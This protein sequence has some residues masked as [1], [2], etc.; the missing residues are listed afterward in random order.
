MTAITNSHVEKMIF[1]LRG[2][3][4]MLD[5]DLAEL[6]GVTTKRL[7]EQVR[8]NFSRF[9]EDF[10]FECDSEDLKALRSQIATANA[11]S[12]WNHKRRNSPMVFTEYGVSMLCSVLNSEKAIQ[13]NIA[14]IKTFIELKKIARGD[15]AL[16]SE[17]K[18][19]RNETTAWFKIVFQRLDDIEEEIYPNVEVGRK[20]IGLIE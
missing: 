1:L 15:S 18:E 13:I 4:V 8:R 2:Q 16:Q 17:L 14:I 7:N 6:Y 12:S 19:F 10:M 9:P 5:S 20:K 3:K 11:V